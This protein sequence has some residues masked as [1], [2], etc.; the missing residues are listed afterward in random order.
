MPVRG[1]RLDG[2]GPV[3]G[4]AQS[5]L[6]R[7]L[8]RLVAA[9]RVSSTVVGGVVAVVGL[10]PPARPS[11]V[12]PAVAGLLLW[13]AL[14][15]WLVLGR[16]SARLLAAVD[17]LV[18]VALCLSRDG[19]VAAEALQVSAGT[20][21]VDVVAG[22]SVCTAQWVLRQPLG[23]SAG[24]V[25]AAAAALGSPGSWE[26]PVVLIVTTLLAA[27]ATVVLHRE[28]AA[29]DAAHA[30]EAESRRSAE[31]RAAVRTDERDQQRRLHDTVLATLTMVN[32]GSIGRD[33]VAL[34][35]RA[36]EDLAVI[37]SLRTDAGAGSAARRSARLDLMLRSA[38]AA[39][40]PGTP[41]DVTIDVPAAEV[42]ADVAAAI[43]Q[44]VVE[45]LTNVARHAR[46]G[47]AC[48]TA[49]GAGGGVR[50]LVA[51][52]GA[53]FD[54]AAVPAHRRGIRES[55]QGRMRSVGGNAGVT[56][57]PGAG[58]TIELW[59]PDG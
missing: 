24:L 23:V 40:G 7:L 28:A 47:T 12:V 6:D 26:A 4:P 30:E 43:T 34:R 15:A 44:S 52:E 39:P 5:G 17:V 33:S 59:W 32:T 46:T 27:G 56:S 41:I 14:Y 45:A 37:E 10:A 54:P 49:H 2:T 18:V 51:D 9:V 21:W 57:R 35:G 16:G 13:S 1:S 25:I 38:V 22:A 42:P 36:R 11:W 20:S 19:L 50:V 48:V 58:T 3:A 8:R 31:V 55:I 53:G 29:S